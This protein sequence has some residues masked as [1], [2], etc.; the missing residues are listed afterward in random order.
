MNHFEEA[1]KTFQ[2]AV[3]ESR[4]IQSL[5][6]LAWIY[7]HEKSNSQIAEELLNEV[8][9]MTPSSYF[10]YN[11]LGEIYVE[12]NEW[13]K[14]SDILT[15]SIKIMPT[16]E[17]FNNLGIAKY[18]LRELQD[19]SEL[20][21]KGSKS[22]SDYSL[23]SHIKC[24][25]ELNENIRAKKVLE[26]FN[27]TDD[28]FVGNVEVAELYYEM[29]EYNESILW[30]EKGWNEYYKQPSWVEEYIYVLIKT[31]RMEAAKEKLK[32]AM[33]EKQLEIEGSE[34]D[35]CNE[36]WTQL[37]KDMN[38]QHLNEEYMQYQSLI[39]RILS[40]YTPKIKFTTSLYSGC[41]LFGCKR[42]NNT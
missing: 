26:T 36:V 23:Y 32:I 39:E 34:Q 5:T 8:L 4:D 20:F 10:P 42:H 28:E 17:A 7:Y 40:G 16:P 9:Q 6:N 31:N 35:E 25:I 18:H 24:L 33:E 21:L 30:F 1:L 22:E 27:E 3:K 11:L 15:Q 12:R 38:I 14:A 19:A 29:N 41:Y 37:D 13:R 2:L